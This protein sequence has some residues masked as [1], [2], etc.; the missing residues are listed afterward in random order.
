MASNLGSLGVSVDQIATAIRDKLGLEPSAS[1][2][3]M[4]KPVSTYERSLFVPFLASV[5]GQTHQ[6]R[7]L[8]QI[9]EANS[10]MWGGDAIRLDSSIELD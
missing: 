3:V 8:F 10:R 4:F 1:V 2:N 9:V 5:Q 6:G 7:V